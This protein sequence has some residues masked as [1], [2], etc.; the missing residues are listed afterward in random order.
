MTNVLVDKLK[1]DELSV[2]NLIRT[3]KFNNSRSRN[4]KIANEHVLESLLKY[5]THRSGFTPFTLIN[6]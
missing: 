6:K 5:L 1:R 4:L 3:L 2:R